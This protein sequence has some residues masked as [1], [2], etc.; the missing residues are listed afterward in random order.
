MQNAIEI[1][2]DLIM[3]NFWQKDVDNT[4]LSFLPTNESVFLHIKNWKIKIF[5]D[6]RN[7]CEVLSKKHAEYVYLGIERD[8]REKGM[9]GR[10]SVL[11]AMLNNFGTSNQII[12][13]TTDLSVQAF[14][15]KN[16]IIRG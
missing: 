4:K 13:S 11:T 3:D 10:W 8:Q 12:S 1:C 16:K 5:H 15:S 2:T 7:I 6:T 9:D 14:W